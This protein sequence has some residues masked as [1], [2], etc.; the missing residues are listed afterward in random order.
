MFSESGTVKDDS[1]ARINHSRANEV[2]SLVV[3]VLKQ[4]KEVAN[5]KRNTGQFGVEFSV[6]VN[7]PVMR[8]RGLRKLVGPAMHHG[9]EKKLAWP[10]GSIESGDE[11]ARYYVD[12]N[13][14]GYV[15]TSWSFPRRAVEVTQLTVSYLRGLTF[16]QLEEIRSLLAKVR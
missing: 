12:A 13:S 3:E 16:L 11:V 9:K 6:E 4:I 1:A 14:H 2:P 8:P 7:K 5:R 15:I 10:V